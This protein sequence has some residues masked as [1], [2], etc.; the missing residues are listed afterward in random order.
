MIYQAGQHFVIFDHGLQHQ[1]CGTAIFRHHAD[2]I[3]NG[4][5]GALKVNFFSTYEYLAAVSMACA[6][7][8]FH[9]LGATCTDQTCN[10][11]NFTFISSEGNVLEL[12]TVGKTFHTQRL[13]AASVLCV[14]EVIIDLAAHHAGHQFVLG[15][16]LNQ[17]RAY[18]ATVA[19]NRSPIADF[20]DF[21]HAMADI[22]DGNALTPQNADLLKQRINLM[23]GKGRSRLVHDDD[24]CV[25]V[26]NASDFNHLLLCRSQIPG[27]VS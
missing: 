4:I 27:H 8:R 16:I 14:H 12:T 22:G 18:K 15:D 11:Q 17:I 24:F 1:A 9:C 21:L 2:F 25:F 20:K 10:P 5:F 3:G 7:N 23:L 26:N 19:K 6:E 13:L